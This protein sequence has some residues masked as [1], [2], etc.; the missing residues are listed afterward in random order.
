MGLLA[1]VNSPADIRRLSLA[2]LSSLAQEIRELIITV[3]ARTGGHV[4]PGLGVVELTLALHRVFETPQDCIIWDVGHQCYAHKIITGRRD[5]FH[6]LRQSGGIA[7]FPKRAESEFD[8]FDTGH[9]GDSISVALGLATGYQRLSKSRRCVAVIGDGSIATGMA[10]EALNHAGAM[11][12]DLIVVLN[13]NEMSIAK[14]TGA[15]AGYLNRMITGRM[16]N[17]I[18]TDAWELLGYLPRNIGS[19]A[20]KAARKLEEGLKNLFVPSLLFEELGF[21]Y[22]GPLDGHNLGEL[23]TTFQRVREMRGPVLVH[24]VTVKGRG[25]E[26]AMREPER[27]HGTPP[28]DPQTGKSAPAGPSFTTA[29]GEQLLRLAE[30][31]ERI[32]AI[33]AGMCLGT[34]LLPFRERFPQRLFDVGICEQHAVAFAAGLAQVGL[35]PVVAI[36]S[37]FLMRAVDQIAVDVCLQGL[38]VVFAVDRAGLVGEDGPTHHGTFDI[39]YLSM[40][41]RIVIMAPR[42]E[43]ILGRM[44]EFAVHYTAGP[45]AIRFPRGC[46]ESVDTFPRGTV[47]LGK[48]E[49]VRTGGDGCILSVGDLVYPALQAAGVLAREGIDL[50]VVDLKFIKPLDCKLIV[51]LARETGRVFTLEEGTVVGGVGAAVS[52]ILEKHNLGGALRRRFGIPD[53]FI[54]HGARSVLL[55]SVG[56][57]ASGLVRV[58]QEEYG[59]R[60]ASDR[61]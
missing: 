37:T 51:E 20:R 25:Y 28:F 31:D 43:L 46:S 38:P 10:F 59:L 12:A 27:F 50:S 11:K 18:R 35:R 57:S 39:V 36:Y 26:P 30:S 24:V 1:K 16:Y 34:G 33:T 60:K 7:G 61:L 32:V 23:I 56:L 4:A 13:D 15:L 19:R 42:N 44:L 49:V 8:V 5:L 53:R 21:R 2:E 6:T 47:E 55:D 58:L 48:A 54:E 52:S 41:P 45:I 3:T 29:F 14:S 17:R 9:S 40:L 22:V